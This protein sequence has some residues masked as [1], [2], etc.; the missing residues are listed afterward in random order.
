M[1]QSKNSKNNKTLAGIAGLMLAAVIILS[2]VTF[3]ALQSQRNTLAGNTIQ[4]ANANL[5]LSADGVAYS[6]SH[7]GFDFN[8]LIP[9]GSAMPAAGYPFYLKNAGST[10]LSI[11]V[12]VSSTP[13]NPNSVDL[14][15]VN[16]LLTT[17]G[18]GTPAQSFSLQS[19]V[20]SFA[21]GGTAISTSGL[22]A[23]GVQQYKLQASMMTD[24]V[25]GSSASL[26]NVDLVFYGT[27]VAN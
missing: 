3:A 15:K 27:A 24:A 22:P 19:L 7:A 12:A 18:A 5:Q 1:R 23:G 20:D 9:G 4:T 2:G 17:V 25:T 11:K 6:D 14:T 10:P 13:S 21:A 8:N 26:G 16:I